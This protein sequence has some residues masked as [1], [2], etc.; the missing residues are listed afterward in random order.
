M[1]FK[2]LVSN[3]FR[4]LIEEFGYHINKYVT[5]PE[6][7]GNSIVRF[8]SSSAGINIV[9]DR[10]QVFVAIGPLTSQEV[11]WFDICDV[12][13]YFAPQIEAVYLFPEDLS[14]EASISFQLERLSN[15][16]KSYCSP[17][18]QGDFLMEREIR[19][20]Q[21]KRAKKFKEEIKKRYP[22]LKNLD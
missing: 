12:I 7:F 18:L 21:T 16:I 17:I 4:F 13:P 20:N 6:N 3:H 11:E 19:D 22:D 5:D 9:L 8:E 2:N 1:E 14:G 15:L 10:G